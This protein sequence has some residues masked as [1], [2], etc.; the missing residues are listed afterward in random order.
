[1]LHKFNNIETIEVGVSQGP[2]QLRYEAD[3]LAITNLGMA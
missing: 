2:H 3:T 1:M